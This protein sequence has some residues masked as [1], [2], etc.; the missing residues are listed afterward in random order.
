MSD[1]Y[2]VL[3]VPR[4]ATEDEITQAYRQQSRKYHPDLNPDDKKSEAKMKEING[5]YEA[6]REIRNG[7]GSDQGTYSGSYG[8][9]FYGGSAYGQ[10]NAYGNG[11]GYQNNRNGSYGNGQQNTYENFNDFFNGEGFGFHFGFGN[12][13][14]NAQSKTSQTR[15][16]RRPFSIIR[17]ILYINLA[18][19]FLSF[20]LRSCSLIGGYGY[21]RQY[22][23]DKDITSPYG[24]S[25][26]YTPPEDIP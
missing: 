21:E 25:Q 13:Q 2:V 3:G 17:I 24:Y 4:T 19:M 6:I 12:Q 10:Q 11:N 23:Y 9:S 15:S 18:Q 1:P 22:E 14:Q 20:L 5:A 8:S 7:G 26:W 16:P